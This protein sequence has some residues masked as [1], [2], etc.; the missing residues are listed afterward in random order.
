MSASREKQNRQ[1]AGQ[2]ADPKTAREAQQRKEEK[3]SNLLYG[4]IAAA[5]VIAVIVSI[6]WRS[7][8]TT[9]MTTAATI[10]GEKYTVGEVNYYYQTAYRNLIGQNSY[11]SYLLG[12]DTSKSLKDQEVSESAASM[13]DIEHLA[14]LYS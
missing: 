7:G 12:L 5:V 6:V 10:D 1:A 3:R 11:V 13:L 9:K 14:L 4:V 8:I 2:R